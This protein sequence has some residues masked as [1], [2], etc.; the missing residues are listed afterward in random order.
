[1]NTTIIFI[2]IIITV[3][4]IIITVIITLLGT[5]LPKLIHLNLNEFKESL[6]PYAIVDLLLALV[7]T[8]GRH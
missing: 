1:M 5:S 2:I 6:Q 8:D 7:I 4:I 3:I